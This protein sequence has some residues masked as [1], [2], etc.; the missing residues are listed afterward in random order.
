MNSV[1]SGL[2]SAT[3]PY[4]QTKTLQMCKMRAFEFT[5]IDFLS[6]QDVCFTKTIFAKFKLY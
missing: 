3:D 1:H 5:I 4:F 6:Q 2:N